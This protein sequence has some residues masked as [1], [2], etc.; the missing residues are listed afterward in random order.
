M[1]GTVSEGLDLVKKK[2]ECNYKGRELRDIRHVVY[3]FT[4]LVNYK[5]LPKINGLSFVLESK[6]FAAL[7]ILTKRSVV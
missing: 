3:C 5:Y 6:K 7:P 2:M 4:P 1:F